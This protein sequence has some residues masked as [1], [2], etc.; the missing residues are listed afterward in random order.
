[1]AGKKFIGVN[2]DERLHRLIKTK[3]VERGDTIHNVV[4]IALLRELDLFEE[5]SEFIPEVVKQA[6]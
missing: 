4:L 1:M 3:I 2:V 6:Q 5:A